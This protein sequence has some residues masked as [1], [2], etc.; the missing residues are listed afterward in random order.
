VLVRLP[1][2][3]ASALAPA[4]AQ[5]GANALTV[6]APPRLTVTTGGQQ[7]TGRHYSPDTFA[8]A[9]EALSAVAAL[10]LGLPLIGAGGI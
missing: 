5:A 9:L 3:N 4:A 2:A 7:V 1:L 8:P 6:A 10:D